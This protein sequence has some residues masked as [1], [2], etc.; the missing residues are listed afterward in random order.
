KSRREA[1]QKSM[2]AGSGDD[3]IMKTLEKAVAENE[4]DPGTYNDSIVR[5]LI[6]CIKVFH[7]G[8]LEV[9]FG[10]GSLIEEHL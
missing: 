7:D 4:S 1:I 6:E 10:G 8:R 2:Q 3:E 9:Y 5:S